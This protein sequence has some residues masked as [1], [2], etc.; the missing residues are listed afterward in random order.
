MRL[1]KVGI[2]QSR[3]HRVEDRSGEF[4]VGGITAHIGGPD[5]TV[6]VVSV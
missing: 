1:K 6:G 3:L 5:L 2:L 4:V